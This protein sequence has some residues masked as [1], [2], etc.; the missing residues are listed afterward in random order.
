MYRAEDRQADVAT[1]E[2]A[3][4]DDNADDENVTPVGA[5][6]DGIST[7]DTGSQATVDPFSMTALPGPVVTTDAGRGI[8]ASDIVAGA[9]FPC[10]AREL[11]VPAKNGSVA[12]KPGLATDLVVIANP[13]V[14]SKPSKTGAGRAGLLVSPSIIISTSCCGLC[15]SFSALVVFIFLASF[16]FCCSSSNMASNSIKT[17][18]N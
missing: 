8:E 6:D 16:S 7:D 1:D 12:G 10:N 18:G 5:D 4:V 9:T 15:S 3:A 17:L 14:F 13:L 11:E 2:G